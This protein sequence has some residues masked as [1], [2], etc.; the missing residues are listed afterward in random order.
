M[1]FPID[2][3]DE[4]HYL[5]TSGIWRDLIRH[6]SKQSLEEH[7]DG[8]RIWSFLTSVTAVKHEEWNNERNSYAYG[9]DD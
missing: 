1:M 2:F 6:I 3:S 5:S 8:S 4:H 7:E 9:S